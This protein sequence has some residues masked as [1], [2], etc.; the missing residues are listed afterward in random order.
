[1]VM[2]LDIDR[3]ERQRTETVNRIY[4]FMYDIHI[5][6]FIYAFTYMSY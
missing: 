1:M 6:M 4:K 3:C 2:D 5:Y